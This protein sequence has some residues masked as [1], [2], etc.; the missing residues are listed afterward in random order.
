MSFPNS[1]DISKFNEYIDARKPI[2][3]NNGFAEYEAMIKEWQANKVLVKFK[4]IG[5][6]MKWSHTT[7]YLNYRRYKQYCGL[8]EARDEK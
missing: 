1:I 2:Q 6:R 5:D 4:S 7:N 3:N 8:E